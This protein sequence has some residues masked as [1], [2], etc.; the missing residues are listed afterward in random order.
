MG[1]SRPPLR[2]GEVERSVRAGRALVAGRMDLRAQWR[3]GIAPAAALATIVWVVVLWQVPARTLPT[4]V[5]LAIFSDLGLVAL[6]FLPGLV[7][8]ERTQRVLA[9]L[10]VSPLEFTEYLVAKLAGLTV[11]ALATSG[12]LVLLTP[13][14]ARLAPLLAGVVL[15]SLVT[16]LIGF[17]I[18]ARCHSIVEFIMAVQLPALPLCLPLLWIAGFDLGPVAAFVPTHAALL[19]LAAAYRPVPGGSLLLASAACLAWLPGLW[20]LA[21]RAFLRHVLGGGA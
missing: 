21:R 9:A 8:Y 16:G 2:R 20:L 13:G 12:A 10:T 4:L 19:L 6:F 15:L 14:R 17:T 7:L 3:Y 5:P 1:T 11:L 18:A